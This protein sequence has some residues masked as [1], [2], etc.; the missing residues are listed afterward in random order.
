M[1]V[2]VSGLHPVVEE[3]NQRS[4][5]QASS[6]ITFRRPGDSSSNSAPKQTQGILSTGRE[7]KLE[8]DLKR[9]LIF[10]VKDVGTSLRP[11]MVLWSQQSRKV[12]ILELTVP[13]EERL[14]EAHERK[15]E[16]YQ[17]LSDQCRQAGWGTWV[18]AVEVGCR[19]FV[20]QSMWRALR[21][22]GVTGRQKKKIIKGLEEAAGRASL[23]VW[24][25][26]EQHAVSRQ[27]LVDTWPVS[28][29]PPPRGCSG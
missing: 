19:G 14:S 3:A 28:A 21:D 5:T 27:Q 20:A 10:P 6:F 24:L 2:L 8:A 1:E 16:K 12:I 26:R 15:L 25:S 23:W 7:W 9:K 4:S 11:D 13:W 18:Y 29:D 22:L 17:E